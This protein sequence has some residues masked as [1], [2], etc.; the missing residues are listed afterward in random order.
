MALVAAQRLA[1]PVGGE[2]A[3][4]AEGFRGAL[5]RVAPWLKS[6]R[7]PKPVSLS[8]GEGIVVSYARCCRPIP[9]DRVHGFVTA[10]RGIVVHLDSCPN[11]AEYRNQAERWVDVAWDQ[12]GER[13]YPVDIRV[14]TVNRRGALAAISST[15]ASAEANIDAVTIETHDGYNSVANFTIEVN[16]R[17]HLAQLM[18]SL[19]AHK[20]VIRITC[21]RG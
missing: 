13:Q 15:I 2:P 21:K 12:N 18:R 5:A 10:G 6:P 3:Q 4:P 9:G 16:D 11:I 19:K 1:D 8:G 14:V 20:E 7:S 17:H